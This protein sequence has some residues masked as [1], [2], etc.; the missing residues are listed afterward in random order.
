MAPTTRRS[1]RPQ[2]ATAVSEEPAPAFDSD[3]L[4]AIQRLERK[5]DAD[6]SSTR[7]R[8][9]ISK[10]DIIAT[11]LVLVGVGIAMLGVGLAHLE[12][13]QFVLA[14][15]EAIFVRS[16]LPTL[17][18]ILT[19]GGLLASYWWM[20]RHR[21]QAT[22]IG[23]CCFSVGAGMLSGFSSLCVKCTVEIL[24][25]AA[26]EDSSDLANPVT[27]IFVLGIPVCLLSQLKLMTTGLQYFGTLKF[28]PP[29]HAFI[30]LSNLVNGLVYFDES[31]GYD[32]VSAVLFLVGCVVTARDRTGGRIMPSTDFIPGMTVE[33]G[34]ELVHG[35]NTTLTRL[36]EEQQWSLREV[37]CWAQGDGGPTEPTPDGGIGYYYL[38]DQKRMLA[39][40]DPDPE[41]CHFNDVVEELSE[42]EDVDSIPRD[43]SMADYFKRCELSESMLKLADAGYANTAGS[44]LD[45]ISLRITCRYE[46]QWIELEDD[47]D[48]RMLPT[49]NRIIDHFQQGVDVRLA[50][51]V[52]TIDYTNPER[53]VLTSKTGT[54][55]VCRRLVVTVPTS[56]FLDINYLPCL[57]EEKRDAV[58]SYGMRRAAKVLL[59]MSESFWPTNTHGVICSGC[60]L[61][62]FWV[63]QTHG[64]GHLMDHGDDHPAAQAAVRARDN[65]GE[66]ADEVQYLVTGFAGAEC[67]D[68]LKE[69]SEDEIVSRFVAQLDMIYGTDDDPK[70]A[71]RSLVRGMYFD[72]G[73]VEYIRGG[74]SYPRVGQSDTAA[75]DLARTIQGRIFFAGEATS[76][77][78]PGMTVHS[79]MDTGTRAATEV[80][81]SLADA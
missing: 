47:G 45:D 31:K 59:H 58:L 72:W 56:V 53:I 43:A 15:I 79:A 22:S 1:P 69:L 11:V 13:Q 25:S 66:A 33:I 4:A 6:D 26:N 70:P 50:W 10:Y 30:I 24:K 18:S 39:Y 61:P 19:L 7:V 29:Y 76:Y 32:A 71:T 54:Q 12:T 17:Y 75:E 46:K 23:L 48:Y 9:A 65:T 67:A 8:W 62:E 20:K 68:R 80:A 21:L 51:P 27:Y 57:P 36:A 40:D 38:G 14:D 63:N 60:F 34:A 28:V 55:L 64:V 81:M 49:L 3:T 52:E 74:Y 73:D 42:M 2:P 78:Q 16:W 41:F 37:F 77:E 44:S 35:A 5:I